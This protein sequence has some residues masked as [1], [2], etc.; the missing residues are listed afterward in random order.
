MLEGEGHSVTEVEDGDR[1]VHM[2][3]LRSF[4][5]C[6]LDLVM[7]RKG[8][9]E[10]AEEIRTGFPGCGI[11]LVSGIAAVNSRDVQDRIDRI[12]VRHSLAKPFT[13]EQIMEAVNETLG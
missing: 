4:D 7:R 8:G 13:R 5:L 12:G 6:I 10:A 2:F 11:I 1:A 9:L 3:Q